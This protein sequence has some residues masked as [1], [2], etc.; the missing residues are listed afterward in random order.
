VRAPRRQAIRSRS[1]GQRAL[2]RAQWLVT[3]HGSLHVRHRPDGAPVRDERS[4]T[5]RRLRRRPRRGLRDAAAALRR[6]HCPARRVIDRRQST[7]DQL[8]GQSAVHGLHR[9]LGQ[10]LEQGPQIGGEDR[11]IV[12]RSVT[13]VRSTRARRQR[14]IDLLQTVHTSRAGSEGGSKS[15][16]SNRP[17][18]AV[19]KPG[20]TA[21]RY[22]ATFERPIGYAGCGRRRRGALVAAATAK[23]SM[24]TR[25]TDQCGRTTQSQLS[26]S[27]SWMRCWS[28]SHL[29]QLS[30]PILG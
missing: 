1:M 5:G 13:H 2:Q 26:R 14:T 25:W 20:S 12:V 6:D 24:T 28:R 21:F 18:E 4:F 11:R 10:A 17:R 15:N 27:A 7:P 30:I 23:C 9:A 19:Q 8:G 29:A 22:T 3:A 16:L